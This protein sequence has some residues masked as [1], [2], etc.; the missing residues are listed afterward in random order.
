M[1]KR[2]KSLTA[3]GV[4][5]GMLVGSGMLAAPANAEIERSKQG[6]CR[7]GAVWDL[8]VERDDGMLEIDFD[9]DRARPVENFRV[10]VKVNR[11]RVWRA[12][13]RTDRDGDVWFTRMVRDRRGPDRVTVRMVSSRGDV[14]RARVRI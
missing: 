6:T 8:D 12:N 13:L 14:C 3:V 2:V 10:V 11:K 5:I 9:V 7:S 4:A 1:S